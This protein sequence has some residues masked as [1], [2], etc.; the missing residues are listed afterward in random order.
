MIISR[1]THPSPIATLVI[2][3]LLMVTPVVAGAEPTPT[4]KPSPTPVKG[5]KSLADAAREIN[6]NK[7][8][9]TGKKSIV[10]DN[11]KV[12]ENADKGLVTT[13]SPNRNS[14]LSG[15]INDGERE[16]TEEEKKEYWRGQY[17]DQLQLIADLEAEIAALD[18]EIPKLWNDF[19]AWDDPVYR[20]GVIKPRLD[21]ALLKREELEKRL[22]EERPKPPKILDQAR[23]DG[24]L[25]GWFRDLK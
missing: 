23:R 6:A 9:P 8:T 15:S 21:E 19:Y 12:A 11:E 18:L 14:S 7:P 22:E 20:D 3:I 16:M 17:R 13:A 25:P 4:P 10:I 5:K 24:A 2:A 1:P